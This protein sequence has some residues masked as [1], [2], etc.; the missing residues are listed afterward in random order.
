MTNFANHEIAAF[1]DARQAEL[2]DLSRRVPMT[3][4]REF[5]INLPIEGGVYV[6]FFQSSVFY[7]GETTS[8]RQRIGMHMRNPENHVL[9]LKIARHLY[10]R[11][12]GLG[13]AGS[14]KKFSE[15]HKESTRQWIQEHLHVCYVPMLLGRKELEERLVCQLN[16][17]FNKRYPQLPTVASVAA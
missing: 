17:E 16:P 10:D 6:F 1:F 13:A 5:R 4:A 3:F 7:V 2:L 15:Q 9:A 8:I 11:S 14:Q 12:H